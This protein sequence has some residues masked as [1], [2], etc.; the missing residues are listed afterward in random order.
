MT[1]TDP[2]GKFV[3]FLVIWAVAEVGLAIYD[4]YDTASTIAHPCA[5]A[6][7]K[8]LAGGL[9]VAGAMLPGGGYSQI[10][11]V[12]KNVA[13]N[14]PPVKTGNAFPSNP[15]DLLPGVPRTVKPNGNQ[16]IH[17]SDKVR[18]RAETHPIKP[19]ETHAPRHHDQHYHVEIRIDPTRS[20]NN[21]NNVQKV[22]PPN[23]QPGHGTGFLP[24]ETF[25]GM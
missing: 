17:A 12:A 22:L 3:P 8:V 4:A 25:P 5:S 21:P 23:Y 11:N 13:K 10:D 14:I 7:D 6:G 1:H 24:G 2:S 9:W 20:W 19:G 15:N 18:I 16:V